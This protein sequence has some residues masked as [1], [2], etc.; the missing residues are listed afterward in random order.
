MFR[1]RRTN[2]DN[3]VLFPH[4]TK[5]ETIALSGG[6]LPQRQR[7][8]ALGRAVLSFHTQVKLSFCRFPAFPSWSFF[9]PTESTINVYLNH[10]LQHP[11]VLRQLT[12]PAQWMIFE[13]DNYTLTIIQADPG[14]QN[15]IQVHDDCIVSE[16]T[17]L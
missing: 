17:D 10:Y 2:R 9:L 16:I 7:A 15:K 8:V 4:N 3:L 5:E 11:A 13:G 1:A 6:R 14:L 12:G